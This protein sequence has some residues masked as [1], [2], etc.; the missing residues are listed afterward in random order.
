MGRQK[1][2]KFLYEFRCVFCSDCLVGFSMWFSLNCLRFFLWVSVLHFLLGPPIHW[3]SVETLIA[4]SSTRQFALHRSTIE[5][6]FCSDFWF[7]GISFWGA[8]FGRGPPP[9]ISTWRCPCVLMFCFWLCLC[10]LVV[11]VRLFRF[12]SFLGQLV[13]LK[14]PGQFSGSAIGGDVFLYRT[15]A[16]LGTSFFSFFPKWFCIVSKNIW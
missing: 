16:T 15:D 9:W 4:V 14:L 10:L 1:N 5:R 8:L 7:M 3:K 11:S 12:K 13:F 6:W 2:M